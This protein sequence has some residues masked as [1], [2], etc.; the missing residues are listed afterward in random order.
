MQRPVHK[1]YT[2]GWRFPHLS[3]ATNREQEFKKLAE[4]TASDGFLNTRNNTPKER[5]Q[6]RDASS[7]QLGKDYC[8]RDS[9]YVYSLFSLSYVNLSFITL[10]PD[11][12][13][14]DQLL[15]FPLREIQTA[16]HP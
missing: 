13:N 3:V 9:F 8:I 15:V 4:K 7:G 12:K 14:S 5:T 6:R 1:L 11:L 16:F 2:V 10:T